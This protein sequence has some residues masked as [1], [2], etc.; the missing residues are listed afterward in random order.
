MMQR[1]GLLLIAALVF[2][3]T[4]FSQ[5]MQDETSR[6]VAGGGVTVAGWTGKV[7]AREASQGMTLNSAKFAKE[8]DEF[9]IVT[10]PA[11][12]YC[13]PANKPSGDYTVMAK[14]DDPKLMNL[15]RHPHP[16]AIVIGSN[17]P[18]TDQ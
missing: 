3:P 18:G 16:Y 14:L 7:D 12:T 17:D 13:N 1:H 5:G 6:P 11:V 15:N 9:H 10:G 4:V 8:G 2:I